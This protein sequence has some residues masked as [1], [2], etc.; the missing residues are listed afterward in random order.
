VKSVDAV[1][2]GHR[3]GWGAVRAVVAVCID[4]FDARRELGVHGITVGGADAEGEAT[5][6]PDTA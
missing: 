4:A 1:I 2:A 6:S 3:D 5:S